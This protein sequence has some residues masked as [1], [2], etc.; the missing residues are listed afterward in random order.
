MEFNLEYVGVKREREREKIHC[1]VYTLSIIKSWFNKIKLESDLLLAI[2]G[3][4]YIP[5][6]EA[7]VRAFLAF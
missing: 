2:Q 7:P 6:L 1:E 5:W 3:N 4:T